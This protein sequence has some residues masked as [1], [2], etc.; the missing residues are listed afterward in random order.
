MNHIHIIAN[1]T[2][3]EIISLGIQVVSILGA[4][5]GIWFSIIYF[6][7]AEEKKEI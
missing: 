2:S 5:I 7:I 3:E 4:T 1:L 6:I